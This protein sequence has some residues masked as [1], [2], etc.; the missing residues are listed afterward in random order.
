MHHARARG[1]PLTTSVT[2]TDFGTL[3]L[4][5]HP[6][7]LQE[8]IVFR[9]LAQRPGEED[10]LDPGAPKLLHQHDLIGIFARPPIRGVHIHAISHTTCAD[11]A[12]ALEGWPNHGRPTIAFVQKR[13]GLG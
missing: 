11:I 12:P 7:D 6:L 10:A 9:A 1:M 2:F 3:I 5:D 4:G 13:H 8:Q